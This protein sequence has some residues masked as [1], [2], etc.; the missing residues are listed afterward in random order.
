MLYTMFTA[1]TTFRHSVQDKTE[2]ALYVDTMS[3]HPSACPWPSI[4]NCKKLSSKN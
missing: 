3:I 2:R 4:S 1:M